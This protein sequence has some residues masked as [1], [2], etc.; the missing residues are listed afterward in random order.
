[1]IVSANTRNHF[2]GQFRV[3]NLLARCDGNIVCVIECFVALGRPALACLITTRS[4]RLLLTHSRG[5]LW[6]I[7]FLRPVACHRSHARQSGRSRVEQ[8]R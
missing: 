2:I 7:G 3:G 6:G 5:Q 8:F 4:R 1:V